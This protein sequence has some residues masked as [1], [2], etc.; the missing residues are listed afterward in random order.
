MD[1]TIF[2]NIEKFVQE[3]KDAMFRDIGRLV[4]VNSVMGES[5]K[6]APFGRGPADALAL[7]LEIAR[8]LGLET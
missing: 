3:N 5:E 1:K 4:A 8:E 2:E 7:A 6:G